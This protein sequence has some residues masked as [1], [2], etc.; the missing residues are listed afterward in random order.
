MKNKAAQAKV[1]A[2]KPNLIKR[3]QIAKPKAHPIIS[4]LIKNS[5]KPKPTCG[6]WKLN[7]TKA[8]FKLANQI[9]KIED[10]PSAVISLGSQQQRIPKYIAKQALQKPRLEK[11]YNA[12]L[13]LLMH[14]LSSVAT[15]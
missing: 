13:N 4:R 11:K 3:A 10:S 8:P 2:D 7:N 9:L 14:L 1:S 15:L 12:I 6:N 5:K